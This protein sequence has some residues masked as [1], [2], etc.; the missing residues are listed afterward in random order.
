MY[1][2][3]TTMMI[4]QNYEKTISPESS[5][6]VKSEL[7]PKERNTDSEPKKNSI[8]SSYT[9]Y[10]MS[11]VLITKVMKNM[12]KWEDGRKWFGRK[13]FEVSYFFFLISYIIT[14]SCCP[15]KFTTLPSLQRFLKPFFLQDSLW[16]YI[17][18]YY[19]CLNYIKIKILKTYF[20]NFFYSFR[21]YSSSWKSWSHHIS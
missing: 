14:S 2:A 3:F 4:I 17:T 13:F 9:R 1:S 18:C 16:S 15:S 19:W 12:R 20:D 21:S 7:Y 11:W 8:S 10:Y 6:F 5:Y